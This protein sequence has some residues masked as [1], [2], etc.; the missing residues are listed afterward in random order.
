LTKP[1][2]KLPKNMKMQNLLN[3]TIKG[4]EVTAPSPTP[5]SLEHTSPTPTSASLPPPSKAIQTAV[6]EAP[7]ADLIP[8]PPC[9][10]NKINEA[11]H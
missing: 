9:Y 10:Y 3:K 1:G 11:I 5:I 6:L 7:Q 2:K 8:H 4:A